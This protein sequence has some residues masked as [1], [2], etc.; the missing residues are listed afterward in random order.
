MAWIVHLDWPLLPGMRFL[1]AS[2]KGDCF[3]RRSRA[4]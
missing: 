4:R 1:M 2:S 3:V